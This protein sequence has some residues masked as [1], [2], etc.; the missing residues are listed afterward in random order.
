MVKRIAEALG[1]SRDL[2]FSNDPTD[3]PGRANRPRDVTL[4]N[5]KAH[6]V[7]QTKPCSIAEGVRRIME[8]DARIKAL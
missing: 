7:L 6:E 3:I 8:A 1:Y 5:A 4:L 2:V